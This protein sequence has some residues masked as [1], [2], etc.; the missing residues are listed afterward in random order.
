MKKFEI[1]NFPQGGPESTEN[2][3]M[4]LICQ[5]STGQRLIFWAEAD[6]P[7]T[8][9]NIYAIKDKPFPIQIQF[10]AEAC[11]PSAKTKQNYNVDYSISENQIIVVDG[12]IIEKPW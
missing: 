3:K 9:L 10:D 6:D 4:R 1:I 11:I 7:Q 8:L 2:E 5:T 12:Q